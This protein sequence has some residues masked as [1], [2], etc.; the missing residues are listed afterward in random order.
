M[1]PSQNLALNLVLSPNLAAT[2]DLTPDQDLTLNQDII[3][4]QIND[5]PTRIRKAKEFLQKNPKEHLITAARIYNLSESTLQSSISQDQHIHGGQNK[6]L[7]EHQK[8][9][10]HQFI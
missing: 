8:H 1:N 10:I 5:I 9:A 2:R 6:I 4:N 7:Q 3:P